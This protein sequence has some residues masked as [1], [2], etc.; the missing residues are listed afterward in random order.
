MI[1]DG[2]APSEERGRRGGL[3]VPR[4]SRRKA[5]GV[6]LNSTSRGERRAARA[7][8]ARSFGSSRARSRPPP[9]PSRARSDR[10]PVTG[11]A[12]RPRDRAGDDASAPPPRR[13]FVE[14]LFPRAKTV[15]RRVSPALRAPARRF[16]PRASPR[17]VPAATLKNGA[18]KNGG[19]PARR[20]GDDDRAGGAKGRPPTSRARRALRDG[21]PG[22]DGPRRGRRRGRGRGR[23][24]RARR[25]AGDTVPL[26]ASLASA[27]ATPPR[28]LAGRTAAPREEEALRVPSD[29]P[30]KNASEKPSR[31]RW[32]A[33]SP[34]RR[35]S[36]RRAPRWRAAR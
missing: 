32:P 34:R 31:G 20:R 16:S 8:L 33:L 9:P 22:G 18:Y 14:G 35:G 10:A 3:K 2:S 19:D 1:N 6:A 28:A 12:P 27:D 21:R 11:D 25:P 29:P 36:A 17:L 13:W 23:G 30:R 24:R 7:A 4:R 5:R 26:Y 15:R